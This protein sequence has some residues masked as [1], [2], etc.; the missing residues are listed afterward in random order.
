MARVGKLYRMLGKAEAATHKLLKGLQVHKLAYKLNVRQ[1]EFLPVSPS[2]MR[3]QGSDR[4]EQFRYYQHLLNVQQ[5]VF[6]KAHS[7]GESP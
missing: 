3:S 7:L 6:F 1:Q 5:F 2:R 4:I